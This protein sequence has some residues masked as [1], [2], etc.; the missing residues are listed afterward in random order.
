M[1]VHV[2]SCRYDLQAVHERNQQYV[3]RHEVA[4]HAQVLALLQEGGDDDD[5]TVTEGQEYRSV[6]Y[7][8]S[9]P[10]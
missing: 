6:P 10:P 1:F 2:H 8:G 5:T 3:V 7:R 9:I 4:A